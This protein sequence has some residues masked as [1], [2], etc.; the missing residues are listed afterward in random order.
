M[1]HAWA[2]FRSSWLATLVAVAALGSTT[3]ASAQTNGEPLPDLPALP[4][5]PTD[6]VP[7][8]PPTRAEPRL[9]PYMVE[10]PLPPPDDEPAP[11]H[12]PYPG[13]IYEP[14][15]PP[16]PPPHVAPHSSFWVG[17]R[18]GFLA[19]FGKLTYDYPDGLSGPAWGD[20]A[21]SGVSFEL[22]AGGRFS[23]NF[24]VF[25]LWEYGALGPG[26]DKGWFGV[27]QTSA[28]THLFGAGFRFSSH[29]DEVGLAVEAAFGFRTF[30]ADFGKD[31]TVT[32]S[33][34]EVRIGIGAD[35]RLSRDI[36]LSPMMQITNGTFLDLRVDQTG[37]PSR[38]IFGYDAPHGTFGFALGAHFDMFP[39]GN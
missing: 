16:P 31:I 32:A 14:P 35:I 25:G 8:E 39:S 17:G 27:D 20:I 28:E 15:P 26:R 23:R 29:P 9:P 34:P 19:P 38:S 24:L 37:R 33:S 2:P 1:F 12:L 10:E 30:R 18:L 5:A 13:Y 3:L 6:E 11:P 21:G 36:T 4:E 22:D 7:S